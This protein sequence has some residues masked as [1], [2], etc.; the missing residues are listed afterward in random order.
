M[1]G[2]L[3]ERL[4]AGRNKTGGLATTAIG[5]IVGDHIRRIWCTTKIQVWFLR[6][7]I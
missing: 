7:K 3:I 2:L 1:T 4:H 5:S 6:T